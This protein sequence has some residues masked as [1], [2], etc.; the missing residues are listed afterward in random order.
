[1]RKVGCKAARGNENGKKQK[2]RYIMKS[3]KLNLNKTTV[4]NL[5]S[6]EMK[7]ARGGEGFEPDTVISGGDSCPCVFTLPYCPC[8]STSSTTV[9]PENA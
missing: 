7:R 2:R 3:K 4:A 9:L 5:G 1:M 8:P 6:I